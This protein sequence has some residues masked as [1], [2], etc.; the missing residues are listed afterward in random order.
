MRDV[1][2]SSEHVSRMSR[3]DLDVQEFSENGRVSTTETF[4][5]CLLVTYDLSRSSH[6]RDPT[7]GEVS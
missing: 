5:F 2:A 1:Q 6:S 7:E 4:A 3:E